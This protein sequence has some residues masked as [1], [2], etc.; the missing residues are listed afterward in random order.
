MDREL[1]D[2]LIATAAAA[3]DREDELLDR[4]DDQNRVIGIV[5]RG[6]CHGN[7]ELCHRA[8]HVFVVNRRG[9][10]FLQK[11]SL[12][13]R[14]QP[15]RWDTSVG[16]HVVAGETY[17]LAAR[18]ELGEELG[19]VLG[20]GFSLRH[21][22][23]YLWRSPI[24]TEYVRTFVLEHEGPFRLQPEEIED[25]RF[26]TPAEMLAAVETG[27]LTPN[28]EAEMRNLGILKT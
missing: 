25:G 10:Y 16:G 26:W 17:E 23:D 6:D 2:R 20:E 21:G 18:K 24:E 5:R 19:I 14:I 7:P 22:H 13:K 15:G 3:A 27:M 4:V 11:R 8:V 1:V 28:L 9:E 12:A